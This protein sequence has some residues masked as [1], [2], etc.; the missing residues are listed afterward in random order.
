M[1]HIKTEAAYEAAMARIDELLKVVTDDMPLTNPL[2]AELDMLSE[3]VEEYE[4]VHYPF[5]P[6]EM[7]LT[8]AIK[9]SLHKKKMTQRDAAALLGISAPHFSEIVRGKT[10]PS[11][12]LA[13]NI[14][15]KL[16]I[17]AEVVLGV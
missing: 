6:P 14:S 3:L 2:M 10:E 11:L 8:E 17:P 12:P 15:R 16:D 13:R 5:P 4:E 7:V 9:E 1:A